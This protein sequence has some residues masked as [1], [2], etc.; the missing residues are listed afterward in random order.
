M[1]R[2]FVKKFGQM[3]KRPLSE[4]EIAATGGLLLANRLPQD[5]RKSKRHL[6]RAREE[7]RMVDLG[8]KAKG[9]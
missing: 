7:A 3:I 6:R 5:P 8:L 1:T 2:G 9:K 4:R